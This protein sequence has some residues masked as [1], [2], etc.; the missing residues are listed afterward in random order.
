MASPAWTAPS[1][2]STK[3]RARTRS[4]SSMPP[5]P[6]MRCAKARKSCAAKWLISRCTTKRPDNCSYG[7]RGQVSGRMSGSFQCLVKRGSGYAQQ[8]CH[9]SRRVAYAEHAACIERRD[10]RLA[11]VDAHR[12]ERG[13]MVYQELTHQV[14]DLLAP[15]AAEQR[16]VPLAA[17][18][19]AQKILRQ[20][21]Q[22]LE[23]AH[24]HVDAEQTDGFAPAIPQ[25]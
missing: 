17:V 23:H 21:V 22:G 15:V 25:H 18:G 8:L 1:A 4:W 13:A 16:R 10:Q 14:V 3:P 24:I 7:N 6:A 11:G 2:A 19:K 20:R 9:V 12:H 5:R